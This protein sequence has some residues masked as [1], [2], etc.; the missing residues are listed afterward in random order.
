MSRLAGIGGKV[1]KTGV[2]VVRRETVVIGSKTTT[3]RG[4][5]YLTPAALASL[6]AAGR[7]RVIDRTHEAEGKVEIEA[8]AYVESDAAVTNMKTHVWLVSITPHLAAGAR[9]EGPYAVWN[10]KIEDT[11]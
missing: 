2:R 9:I 3:A 8:E 10:G 6:E 7:L 5:R 1:I 4:K 11:V